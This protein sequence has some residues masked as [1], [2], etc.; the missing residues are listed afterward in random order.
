MTCVVQVSGTAATL[1]RVFGQ[2]QVS[3]TNVPMRMGT[4]TNEDA[5]G[6]TIVW[7]L[8]KGQ[9]IRPVHYHEAGGAR[10]ITATFQVA[11]VNAPNW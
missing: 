8:S 5:Y 10:D 4:A 9:A 1:G 7:P 2:L 3:G 11:M 6:W